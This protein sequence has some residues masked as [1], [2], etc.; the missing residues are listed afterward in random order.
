MDWMQEC[1]VMGMFK[2]PE[3]YRVETVRA[4]TQLASAARDEGE[5][6]GVEAPSGWAT[7]R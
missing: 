1:D 7:R 5:A 6:Q 2:V 3:L 4:V